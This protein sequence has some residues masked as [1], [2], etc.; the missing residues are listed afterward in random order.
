MVM[1]SGLPVTVE[2]NASAMDEL[3]A[4]PGTA[5]RVLATTDLAAV[6]VPFRTSYG[7]GGSCAGMVELLDGERE[8]QPT[9]WLDAGDFTVGPTYP[10]LGTRPWADMGELPIDAAAAGNH[11]FDDGVPALLE[12]TRQLPYPLLCANLDVGLPGSAMV[13]TAAGPLGVIGLTHPHVQRLSKAPAPVDDWGERVGPLARELRSRGARWVVAIL[14]DGVDWWPDLEPGGPA[15]RAR[16]ER[17]ADT[18]RPWAGEVDLIVGGHVPDGWVGELA[19]TPAGHAHV[20]AASV[21]VIDL[22]ADEGARPA[23]R[24]W[25]PVPP[26]RPRRATPAVEALDAAAA[27]VV[28]ESRHTWLSL[29]GADRY[30]PDLIAGAL[31]EATGADAGMVLAAQHLTQGSLDGITAAIRAG[32]VTELDLM[33]LFALAD[34][35]PAVVEL[36]PGDFTAMVARHDAIADPAARDADRVWWNWSRMPAGLSSGTTDPDSVAVM[37]WVV[38]RLAELLDRDLAPELAATGARTALLRVLERVA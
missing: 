16:A 14:H 13:D 19:G 15:T 26:T 28:G 27:N 5:L 29:T 35:R 11:E 1:R 3:P 10:L 32:P 2:S 38:P 8:R 18:A 12:A 30:L 31:R 7:E 22:P 17:L 33:W 6:L 20:F 37:P 4:L 24:G 36:R 23:V 21:L 34:D 25:F 9:V